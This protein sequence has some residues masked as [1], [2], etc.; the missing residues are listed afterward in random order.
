MPALNWSR[1]DANFATNHK[2]I[3][4]MGS[5]AGEHALLVYVF[6][7]GYAASHGTDGFIPK[8]AIGLFHGSL[9]DAATLVEAGLWDAV[10]GGWEIHDWREYQPSSEE[11][12]KRSERARHAAARRWGTG[13]AA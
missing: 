9:K 12:Q 2:T 10:N 3:A 5:R 13:G 1:L 7:H 11:A 4:L 8:G 6:S